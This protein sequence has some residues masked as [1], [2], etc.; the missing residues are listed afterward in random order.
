MRIITDAPIE[1]KSGCGGCHSNA[2]AATT[3]KIDPTGRDSSKV[4]KQGYFSKAKREQRHEKRDEKREERQEK[5]AAR[6][7]KKGARPLKSFFQ[8]QKKLFHDLLHPITK[9]A[10]G[11]YSKTLA[12]GSTVPVDTKNLSQLDP[13]KFP[14]LKTGSDGKLLFDK[15][16]L[17]GRTPSAI[18]DDGVARVAT[19][20]QQG[21]TTEVAGDD[22][23]IETYKTEDTEE[24]D[25]KPEGM[26]MTTKVL[27]GFGVLAVVGGL[28]YM[29]TRPKKS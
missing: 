29:A 26:T 20:I 25:E 27:I 2:D 24:G 10:D 22:G 5:R 15:L 18:M 19:I 16:D 17:G 1:V 4:G 9:N 7:A 14:G 11:T 3:A 28:I 23:K 8:G 6:R 12:D 21:A 13:K